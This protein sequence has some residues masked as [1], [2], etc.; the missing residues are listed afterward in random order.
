M[1]TKVRLHAPS[2]VNGSKTL[3]RDH[4]ISREYHPKAGRPI[5]QKPIILWFSAKIIGI[6][7]KPSKALLMLQAG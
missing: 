3:S 1:S 4:S 7:V 2:A 6:R 5:S